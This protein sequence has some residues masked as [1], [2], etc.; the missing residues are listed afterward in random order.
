MLQTSVYA[1]IG[2]LFSGHYGLV[3]VQRACCARESTCV[4]MTSLHIHAGAYGSG[5]RTRIRSWW[6]FGGSSIPGVCAVRRSGQVYM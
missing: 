5:C 4:A 6:P 3:M 1:L 2:M